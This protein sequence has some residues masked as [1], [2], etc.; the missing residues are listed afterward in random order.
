MINGF[1]NCIYNG[2]CLICKRGVLT[3]ISHFFKCVVKFTFLAVSNKK[4]F[5][6][7][8]SY[9][10]H[11]V[12]LCLLISFS[13]HKFTFSVLCNLLCFEGLQTEKTIY[14]NSSFYFEMFSFSLCFVSCQFAHLGPVFQLPHLLS[15]CHYPP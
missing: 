4:I 13:L 10:L 3:K 5:F 8:V 15:F 6:L 12:F 14:F 9:R 2:K 7:I 11:L 1:L